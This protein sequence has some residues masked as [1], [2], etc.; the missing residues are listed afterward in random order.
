MQSSQAD[1]SVRV[2][3]FIHD[4]QQRTKMYIPNIAQNLMKL[5][6]LSFERKL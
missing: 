6:N 4:V 3:H 5:L 2:M 1:S